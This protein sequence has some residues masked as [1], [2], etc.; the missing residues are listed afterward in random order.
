[1]SVHHGAFS[2]VIGSMGCLSAHGCMLHHYKIRA[3]VVCPHMVLQS[4]IIGSRFV[5]YACTWLHVPPLWDQG[6]CCM[7]V[8]GCM[9]HHYRIKACV[10]CLHI[11]VP[12]TIIDQGLC[13]MS[14]HGCNKLHH[15]RIKVCVVRQ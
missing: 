8:H 12:S 4:T 10:V 1:M 14:V 3:C 11:V 13:C 15:Y 2:T 5:L 9:L 7:F 6:V